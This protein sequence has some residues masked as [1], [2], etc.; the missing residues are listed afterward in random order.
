MTMVNMGSNFLMLTVASRVQGAIL[1][2]PNPPIA[3]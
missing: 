3:L 2:D 1:H